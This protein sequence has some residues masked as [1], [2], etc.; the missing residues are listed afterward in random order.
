M[1]N[2]GALAVAFGYLQSLACHVNKHWR[3]FILCDALI[4]VL[5]TR[6]IHTM[7]ADVLTNNAV[8]DPVNRYIW[9]SIITFI[10]TL[11][12]IELRTELVK[13]G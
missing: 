1:L 7:L 10:V 12:V 6:R 3:I 9:P 13:K 11:A 5:A 2:L 4:I 8:E